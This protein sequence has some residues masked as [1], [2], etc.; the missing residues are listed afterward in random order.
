MSGFTRYKNLSGKSR[1]LYY[2]LDED[3]VLGS[4]GK[5]HDA[6]IQITFAS[7]NAS[8][9]TD[10]DI[11]FYTLDNTGGEANIKKMKKLAVKGEGLGR[12]VE[13]KGWGELMKRT[14]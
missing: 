13:G 8:K 14:S 10:L 2:T 7:E 4:D 6:K 3:Q 12:F 5:S 1:A 11:W 9:Q